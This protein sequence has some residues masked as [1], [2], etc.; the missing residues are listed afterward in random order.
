[1]ALASVALVVSRIWVTDLS[2]RKLSNEMLR[3]SPMEIGWA[4]RRNRPGLTADP[5]VRDGLALSK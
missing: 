2:R 3:F 4:L 1:M 5:E